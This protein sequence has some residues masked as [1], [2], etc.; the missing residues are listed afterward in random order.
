MKMSNETI[1]FIALLLCVAFFLNTVV[2][3]MTLYNLA[4]YKIDQVVKHE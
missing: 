1:G 2:M 4:T 3:D